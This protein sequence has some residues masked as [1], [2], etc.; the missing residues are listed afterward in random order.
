MAFTGP[1]VG[2]DPGT[3]ER[4][5]AFLDA[6]AL[7]TEATSFGGVHTTAERRARWGTDAISEGFIRFSAGCEDTAD[8]LADVERALDAAARATRRARDGAGPP[9]GVTGAVGQAAAAVL[10]GDVATSV[11]PLAAQCP[12]PGRL[13]M[14]M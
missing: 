2:F 7:V 10:W 8:L 6:C 3:A 1:L 12:C 5:Q 11:S 4:A 9:A 14:I 13:R